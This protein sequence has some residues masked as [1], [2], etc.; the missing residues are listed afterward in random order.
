MKKDYSVLG[1]S[2]RLSKLDED[3]LII[4]SILLTD[5]FLDLGLD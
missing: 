2:V 5:S 4:N 3:D 1:K